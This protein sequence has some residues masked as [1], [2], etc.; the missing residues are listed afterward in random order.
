MEWCIATCLV[1]RRNFLLSATM[2]NVFI[3]Q[4]CL[5][6]TKDRQ[7]A[8]FS[9]CDILLCFKKFNYSKKRYL[10]LEDRRYYILYYF[11]LSFNIKL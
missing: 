6:F 8:K 3:F 10:K 4:K 2:I 9:V 11:Q 7:L 5:N 1:R